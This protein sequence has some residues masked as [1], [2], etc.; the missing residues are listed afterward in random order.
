KSHR[1]NLV[2]ERGAVEHIPEDERGEDGDDES[3]VEARAF[4]D[5]G[6]PRRLG[7]LLCRNEGGVYRQDVLLFEAEIGDEPDRE[8]VEHD[9]RDDFVRA[10]F[11]AQETGQETPEPADDA[12]CEK[13]K[14]HVD[15]ARQIEIPRA[16]DGGGETAH[17]ELSLNA[18][19]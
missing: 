13:T 18:D 14:W 5:S 12:G 9:G 16:D 8:I 19:I 4:K 1:A 17:D 6:Q 3:G 10:G 15:D 11:G 7:D 2:A